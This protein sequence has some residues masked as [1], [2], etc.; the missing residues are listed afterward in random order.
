MRNS[1]INVYL[2]AFTRNM[3][4]LISRTPVI[5]LAIILGTAASGV[6]PPAALAATGPDLAICGITLSPTEPMIGEVITITVGVKNQ[7]DTRAAATRMTCYLDDTILNTKSVESLDPGI[8]ATVTFTWTA[9]NGSHTVKAIA[10]VNEALTETDETNNSGTYSLTTLAADLVVQSITWLPLN[11]SRGDTITISITIQNKGTYKSRN[12]SFNFLIDNASRGITEIMPLDPGTPITKT[13]NWIVL[14]GEHTFRVIVDEGN[15]TTE[16][17]ETNNTLTSIFDA[18][19][20]DLT[21]QKVIWAPEPPSKDDTVSFDVTITN[22][23]AG[24]ADVSSLAYYI[25]NVLIDTI[26]VQ[27]LD[28]GASRILSFTW[29]ATLDAHTVRAVADYY[30]SVNET[31]EANNEL[32]V[33]LITLRPDLAITDISWLPLDVNAGDKVTFTVKLKNQG[34]G[35]A[36]ASSTAFL[37]DYK[38]LGFIDFTSLAAGEEKSGTFTWTAEGGTHSVGLIGDY[39]QKNTETNKMNNQYNTNINVATPDLIISSITFLP[40]K[41]ALDEMVTITV[42]VKNQGEG[43]APSSRIAL[44]LDDVQETIKIIKS[45]ESSES[46]SITYQCKVTSGHHIFHALVD[47]DNEVREAD[48]KN[49]SASMKLAPNMPDLAITNVS[50]SPA[51][52]MPGQDTIFNIDIEN[53]GGV[54]AGVSRIAFY[55]DDAISGYNDIDPINAGDKVTRSFTWPTSDGQHTIRLVADVKGQITEIDEG[56]NTITI[57][58]PPPDLTVQNITIS[59]QNYVTGDIVTISASIINQ[60]GN[61]TPS[62]MVDLYVDDLSIG[63]K[64]VPPLAAVKPYNISFEWI[65]LAGDHSFKI[66]ADTEN[67]VMETDETN[68]EGHASSSTIVPDLM[69]DGI[70]WQINNRLNGNEVIFTALIKNTGACESGNFSLKYSFDNRPDIIQKMASIPGDGTTTLVF[71]AVLSTGEHDGNII[72]DINEEIN[73]IDEN[74]NNYT[75]TFSSITPDLVVRSIT[76]APITADIGDNVTISVKVE[77]I[78]THKAVNTDVSLT[79]DGVAAG[80]IDIPEIDT[81]STVTL[82]FPWSVIEGEHVFSVFADASQS[83]AECD[84]TNNNRE[85]TLTFTKLEAPVKKIPIINPGATTEPGLLETWWWLL[86]VIGGVLGLA[87][88]YGTIRNMRKG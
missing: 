50:W 54:D 23:G 67:V 10:D 32:E 83:V 22:L 65:A 41:P 6:F 28:A 3:K 63:S 77:N 43:D 1:R 46:T 64:K 48:E 56:N 25:D 68:N 86:L 30:K 70:S 87:M 24:R 78:G 5:L 53:I 80:V 36:G 21:V 40:E 8:A 44:D 52:I 73:E 14:A 9:T 76:W 34:G 7:G 27:A 82:D 58:I 33:S 35:K 19:A 42:T 55:V 13:L 62:F 17:D 84:E 18:M 61:D 49:N 81:G 51:D 20:P 59:P 16:G 37:I 45:L 88:L 15:T 79:I 47:F 57:T 38:I 74:N 2:S 69:V 60:K 39:F 66:C 4:T 29:K 85:R 26:S 75:F 72:L 71:A 11:P 31:N 12:T